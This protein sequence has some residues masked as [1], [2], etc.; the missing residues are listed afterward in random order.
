MLGLR[1]VLE[2]DAADVWPFA[3]VDLH[4]PFQVASDRE[5]LA[6]D[7]AFEGPLSCMN[8]LVWQQCTGVGEL[9]IAERTEVW[10]LTR[11]RPYVPLA[12]VQ[13]LELLVALGAL[14]E[15][16]LDDDGLWDGRTARLD[17]PHLLR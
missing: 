16:V 14:V 2:A 7:R 1:E 17:L 8:S 9:L 13:E 6:A 11:V 3:R 4:V 15:L 5:S 10:L 12:V